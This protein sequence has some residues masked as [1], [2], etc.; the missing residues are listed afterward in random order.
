[1]V[2]LQDA[3]P[4]PRS[5]VRP[6]WL[7]LTLLLALVPLA[8]GCQDAQNAG[9]A[10]ISVEANGQPISSGVQILVLL[11]ALSLAPSALIMVTSFTRIVIVLAF[12]RSAIGVQQLPPNQ[13]VIGLALFL[14]IFVM[15]P[16]WQAINS[17]ALQPLLRQEIS[18]DTALQRAEQPLR[19]FMLK[20]TRERDLA[21]M[22]S[23][24]KAP[25]PRT[26]DDVP[27]WVLIPAFS[28]SELKTAFQMGFIIFIPFLIIDMVVSSTLMSMGM[29]FLPPV[30]ISLPFKILL[31]V[32]VDGWHLV[33]RSLVL[34]FG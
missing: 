9:V 33:I 31:F 8:A 15:A 1:M 2:R 22:V 26:V 19:A 3:A 32:L 6:L 30:M 34:S 21:L 4:A 18:Q 5:R 16:T 14:S 28:I 29:M 25:R 17:D 12:V 7:L 27:T 10:R 13:V 11:T 24:S 23:L 20:Q